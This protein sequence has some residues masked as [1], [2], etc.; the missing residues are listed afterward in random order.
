MYA[1]CCKVGRVKVGGGFPVNPFD[2]VRSS[3]SPIFIY[4]FLK[5]CIMERQRISRGSKKKRLLANVTFP[6]QLGHKNGFLLKK[7]IP[8]ILCCSESAARSN[9]LRFLK[10]RS[11]VPWNMST[12]L[13]VSR[14][15]SMARRR[16]AA[17][18]TSHMPCDVLSMSEQCPGPVPEV[19]SWSIAD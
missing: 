17:C 2:G 3:L 8:V 5:R 13:S 15:G 16:N 19:C 14:F 9:F 18:R 12:N 10:C 6:L 7:F 1:R 4:I 11:H